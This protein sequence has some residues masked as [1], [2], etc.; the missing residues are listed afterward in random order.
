MKSTL[1]TTTM[2]WNNNVRRQAL[3]LYR[4]KLRITREM[5]YQPGTCDRKHMTE[6]NKWGKKHMYRLARRKNCGDILWTNI[7]YRYKYSNYEIEKSGSIFEQN[8]FLDHGF[9]MLR[10]TNQLREIWRKENAIRQ[11][12][13]HNV[14]PL[15]DDKP[16]LVCNSG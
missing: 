6:I 15:Y 8:V 13:K 5:G 3:T 1:L 14:L 10:A 16:D 2:T 12:G 11:Y 7:K 4:A 9:E